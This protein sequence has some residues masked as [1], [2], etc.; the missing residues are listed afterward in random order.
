MSNN[1][2]YRYVMGQYYLCIYV[3]LDPLNLIT[4]DISNFNHALSDF[5]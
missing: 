4:K 1:R 3:H 5:L 2:D